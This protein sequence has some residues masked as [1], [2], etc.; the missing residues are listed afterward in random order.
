MEIKVRNSDKIYF[1]YFRKP[2]FLNGGFLLSFNQLRVFIIKFVSKA[3][4]E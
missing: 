3:V 2:L 4:T 1:S